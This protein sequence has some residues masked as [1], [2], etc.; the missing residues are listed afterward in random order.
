VPPPPPPP[1]PPNPSNGKFD[2]VDGYKN[3]T[4]VK[5]GGELYD[6]GGSVASIQNLNSDGE[7]DANTSKTMLFML[8]LVGDKNS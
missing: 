6:V 2:P 4:S 5:M 1:P 3:F 7:M 8:I